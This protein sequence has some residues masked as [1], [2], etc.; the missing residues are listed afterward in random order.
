MSNLYLPCQQVL[1]F[2]IFFFAFFLERLSDKTK[3]VAGKRVSFELPRE[4]EV[5]LNYCLNRADESW[6]LLSLPRRRGNAGE[7]ISYF[8]KPL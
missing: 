1:A 5:H 7:K 8:Q 3:L 2:N 6:T 4:G